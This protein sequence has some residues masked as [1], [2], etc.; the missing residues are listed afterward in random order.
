MG[1]IGFREP[2]ILKKGDKEPNDFLQV[3]VTYS[4]DNFCLDKALSM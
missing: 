2:S 1:S 3:R 4:G